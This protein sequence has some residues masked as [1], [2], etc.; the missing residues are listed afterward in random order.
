[1]RRIVVIAL[2]FGA[3]AA[4]ARADTIAWQDGRVWQDVRVAEFRVRDG[5]PQFRVEPTEQSLPAGLEAGWYEGAQRIEFS[6]AA[7]GGNA[8]VGE[9]PASAYPPI[10]AAVSQVIQADE[11]RLDT[12]QKVRL[13][14]V[15]APE[16][17]DPGQPL[18][19]FGR[20]AFLYTREK[21]N[22]KQVLIEFDERRMDNF[23]RLLGY[24]HLADGTFLNYDLVRSGYGHAWFGER[25]RDDLL[26]QF[27]E[28]EQAARGQQ[29][30]LW[31]LDEREKARSPWQIAEPPAKPRSI[32]SS[33]PERSWAG[34][35]RRDWTQ[36]NYSP[37][38]RS[39]NV[40]IQFSER[41]VPVWGPFGVG[42][43]RST[44]L[45]VRGR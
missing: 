10:Q 3:E 13:L 27:R 11:L 12:G 33:A 37:R 22:G 35:S 17:T 30:G 5:Q 2:L 43:G 25:M 18:E 6:P 21:A 31:N 26:A 34:A 41:P 45:T 38:G 40:D 1:M 14:G 23:G 7:A 28:A 8:L 32:S 15:D 36:P 4:S 42:I 9:S 29:L 24:V 44:E 16:T 39:I 20:E 19:Y